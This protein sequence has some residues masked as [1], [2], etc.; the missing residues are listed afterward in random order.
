MYRSGPEIRAQND[1]RL[2]GWLST[3]VDRSLQV[4]SFWDDDWNY[5]NLVR[6]MNDPIAFLADERTINVLSRKD[7]FQP[8]TQ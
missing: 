1:G 7:N 2:L 4:I 3:K 5:Y 6:W 8:V